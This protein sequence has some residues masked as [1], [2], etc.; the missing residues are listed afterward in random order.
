MTPGYGGML[1]SLPPQSGAFFCGGGRSA[2]LG[3][4]PLKPQIRHRR[5]LFE[6]SGFAK[7][8]RGPLNQLEH[9]LWPHF[10]TGFPVVFDV[11]VIV[12]ADNHERG[13][14]DFGK[15]VLR[16]IRAATAGDDR[17]HIFRAAGCGN[18][19]GCRAVSSSEEADFQVF[20]G[21][22]PGKPIDDGGEPRGGLTDLILIEFVRWV[23]FVVISI[24]EAWKQDCEAALEQRS[25][26]Q[27][28]AR[29]E[30]VAIC[31]M[32]EDDD[33]FGVGGHLED[34]VDDHVFR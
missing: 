9:W 8:V 20:G 26:H 1:A 31:S 6:F 11:G 3:Q 19:G 7:K 28:V 30:I 22:I 15:Q 4:I 5:D 34:P 10:F 25:R 29:A 23:K 27:A 13:S 17:P 24:G 32:G 18:H 12:A 33:G 2:A 16:Q 14:H 21:G